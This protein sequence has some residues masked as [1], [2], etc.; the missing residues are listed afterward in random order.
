MFQLTQHNPRSR[1]PSSPA[2]STLSRR[3]GHQVFR[4]SISFN[5]DTP[6]WPNWTRL[7]NGLPDAAV[8]DLAICSGRPIRLFARRHAGPEVGV[9]NLFAAW[10]VWCEDNG[11]KPGNAQT[12]GR[13][14]RGRRSTA[15][16]RTSA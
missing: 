11:H 1:W 5:G 12:F 4:A 3:H 16:S 9:Q 10:K 13:D 14:L 7:D 2:T 6:S 15:A 8:Q